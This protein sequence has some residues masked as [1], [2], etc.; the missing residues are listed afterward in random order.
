MPFFASP[1][2]LML[3]TD[4]PARSTSA[5]KSGRFAAAVPATAGARMLDGAVA[6]WALANARVSKCE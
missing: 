3:T 5:V 6:A 2:T 4:G 1:T